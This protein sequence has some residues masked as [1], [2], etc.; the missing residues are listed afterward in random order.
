MYSVIF[1]NEGKSDVSGLD[2]SKIGSGAT[3]TVYAFEAFGCKY[4][5]KIIKNISDDARDKIQAMISMSSTLRKRNESLFDHLAWPVGEIYKEGEFVGFAMQVLPAVQ[6]IPFESFFD[7]NLKDR[8]PSSD[9]TSISLLSDL[10]RKLAEL[11]ASLHA[12]GIYVIDLKPQ[13]IRVAKKDLSVFILDCDS[14]SF[15]SPLGRLF[16]AG[17]VSADYICPETM[18]RKLSPSDLGEGQDRYAFAVMAFQMFNRGIHP[19]QGVVSD[20][21]VDAPTNDEKAELGLYAYGS[22]SHSQIAAHPRSVHQCWPTSLRSLFD[23]AFTAEDVSRPSL[24]NWCDYFF[25]LAVDKKFRRCKDFP[26]DPR[27][28]HFSEGQCVECYLNKLQN[29]RGWKPAT[30]VPRKPVP[31]APTTPSPQVL[32]P[33]APKSDISVRYVIAF[34]SV[35]IVLVGLVYNTPNDVSPQ[36]PPVAATNTNSNATGSITSSPAVRATTNNTTQDAVQPRATAPQNSQLSIRNEVTL[37]R[38][39]MYRMRLALYRYFGR[40]ERPPSLN[41]ATSRLSLLP[42]DELN[43]LREFARR[44]N[45]SLSSGAPNRLVVDR[46]LSLP[47]QPRATAPQNSQPPVRNE[48]TLTRSEMHRLRLALYR[49][50]GREEMPPSLNSATNILSS[51]PSDELRML[52]EFAQRSNIS[53]SSGI[54]NRLVVERLLSLPVQPIELSAPP[55]SADVRYFS[56]WTSY[57]GGSNN[58]WCV[59]GTTATRMG[60]TSLVFRPELRGFSQIG[61]ASAEMAWELS[62]PMPFRLGSPVY[63]DIDGV[64][65]PLFVDG[66]SLK[67]PRNADGSGL[68]ASVIRAMRRGSVMKISGINSLTHEPLWLE[69][70]LI[71]FTR[72]FNDM[73]SRCDRS[74]LQVWI[75]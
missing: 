16:P 3:G 63:A 20:T 59:I 26:A 66:T 57:R 31:S 13:N 6:F 32:P 55:V 60:S 73:M 36:R 4:A 28:I 11:L 47:V 58:I 64:N 25:A 68:D 27:H 33:V 71:G 50:F 52:R 70:S 8:L 69:F 75:Q 14:F 34:M 53:L 72:A 39:D 19:F 61:G 56:R 7:Y 18:R 23:L 74:D 41:L 29:D 5:A 10:V 38:S 2:V 21:S 65:F 24:A 46:L 30:D 12:E 9:F 42:S 15:K 45:I 51:L 67:P 48:V 1:P 44:S 49:Y 43:M 40:E 35:L 54:P 17:F 37:T 22:V 62:Y